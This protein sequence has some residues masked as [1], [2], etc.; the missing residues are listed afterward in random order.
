MPFI[1]KTQHSSDCLDDLTLL[2]FNS[3]GSEAVSRK[4]LESTDFLVWKNVYKFL[5]QLNKI[6]GV[7]KTKITPISTQ[8]AY[9]LRSELYSF[10]KYESKPAISKEEES[11]LQRQ[12]SIGDIVLNIEVAKTYVAGSEV[13]LPKRQFDLLSYMMQNPNQVLSREKLV[14][15]VWDV[16]V[17]DN[18]VNLAIYRLRLYLGKSSDRIAGIEGIGYKF[19]SN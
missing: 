6:E 9:K 19:K 16:P 3:R 7:G 18:A 1:F 15:N 10:N 2:L 11:E 14:E 4:E 13:H 17:T 5:H 12:I 8:E